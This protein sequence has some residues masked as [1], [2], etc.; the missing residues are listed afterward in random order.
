MSYTQIDNILGQPIPDYVIN[1]LKIRSKKTLDKRDNQALVYTANKSGWVRV[2]SS[3]DVSGSLS[4]IPTYPGPELA[5]N[6]VLFGGMS[7]Y[8]N[9]GGSGFTYE[10]KPYYSKEAFDQTY[11]FRPMAGITNAKI[12]TQGKLGSILIAEIDFKANT[13]AQLDLIDILYFKIG[14][15]MLVEWG[16]TFY[17]K[18][19]REDA[20]NDLLVEDTLRK[21][22]DSAVDPF[23]GD[24]D[25]ETIRIKIAKAVRET[26]GNYGGMLGIVTNYSFSINSEGGYDCRIKIMAPGMLA[27]SMRVNSL[28]SLPKIYKEAINLLASKLTAI[29]QKNAEIE[30][31]NRRQ[32]E[33]QELSKDPN[34]YPPCVRNLIGNTLELKTFSNGVTGATGKNGEGPFKDYIFYYNYKYSVNQK[35]S[36]KYSCDPSTNRVLNENGEPFSGQQRTTKEFVSDILNGKLPASRYDLRKV[37]QSIEGKSEIGYRVED[38]QDRLTYFY[39]TSKDKLILIQ[40]SGEDYGINTAKLNIDANSLHLYQKNELNTN[41]LTVL[42]EKTSGKVYGDFR[43]AEYNPSYDAKFGFGENLTTLYEAV[44]SYSVDGK[45]VDYSFEVRYD[46][47]YGEVRSLKNTIDLVSEKDNRAAIEEAIYNY[48]S[49][50]NNTYSLKFLRLGAKRGDITQIVNVEAAAVV[51]ATIWIN[52]QIQDVAAK[53]TVVPQKQTVKVP[54]AI[55]F[56]DFNL[57]SQLIPAP[58]S[59]NG[60]VN[61]ID[62]NQSSQLNATQTPPETQQDYVSIDAKELQNFEQAM[63]TSQLETMLRVV[64][65]TTISETISDIGL[66]DQVKSI[67]WTDDKHSDRLYNGLFIDGAMR[68]IAGSILRDVVNAT[69]D[70][71]KEGRISDESR[72]TYL[73]GSMD[74][75][76]RYK[77]NLYYGFHRG[78]MKIDDKKKTIFAE[79]DHPEY[80]VNFKEL[81]TSY[82]IPYYQSKNLVDGGD[83][84]YPTY[85]PLGFF[86]M[87]LNHCCFLY[88]TSDA[89]INIPMFYLDFNQGSNVM[90]SSEFMLTANPYKFVVPFTGNSDSYKKLFDKD[91]ISKDGLRIGSGSDSS[92]LWKYDAVSD[93]VPKFKSVEKSTNN[94]VVYRGKTMNALVSIDYL[95]D[96]VKRHSQRDETN[97]VYFRPLIEEIF[98]DLG[99]CLGSFNIFRLA[100]DDQSNCFYVT[101]DQFIPGENVHYEDSNKNIELPLFGKESIARSLSITTEN[102][103]KLGSTAFVGAN[104]DV[105]NQ[106]TLGIDGTSIGGLNLFAIDRYKK[107]TTGAND[108]A[109]IAISNSSSDRQQRAVAASRFNEAVNSFYYGGLRSEGMVDQ[110]VNYYIERVAKARNSDADPNLRAAMLLPI[111]VNFNTDGISSMAIYQAFTINEELLPYSYKYGMGQTETRK[112]GFIITGLEHTIQNNTWTT[113][114]K[115]NMYYVKRKGDYKQKVGKQD[116]AEKWK[117]IPLVLLTSGVNATNNGIINY[118]TNFV[119][120]KDQKAMDAKKTAEQ[121]LGRT[122]IDNDWNCL[123]AAAYAESNY[124]DRS[125]QATWC[126]AVMINRARNS[127]RT[128]YEELTLPLQFQAVTGTPRNG[129]LPSDNYVKGPSSSIEFSIYDGIIAELIK[130]DKRYVNFTSNLNSAYVDGTDISYKRKLEN[131]PGKIIVGDTIFSFA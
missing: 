33:A 48:V 24:P 49:D 52:K 116:K 97:S 108:N 99:K 41:L 64:Q 18:Q 34:S 46:N 55:I 74:K 12:I 123:I 63:Y 26:E 130:I 4:G 13:K 35:G 51:E 126:A 86:F 32:Q 84:H 118:R 114:V 2:V 42:K 19:K 103:S 91:L 106:S 58:N 128:I 129:S 95:L 36:I 104:S 22:E 20:N 115:A 45:K 88:D 69:G 43:L 27:E 37:Y 31:Q 102:S 16:N 40:N 85:I 113:D 90:L 98:S 23:T 121:Y 8:K 109:K 61:R 82:V 100:Y 29:N 73:N 6:N 94:T 83:I 56:N 93:Y 14:Y 39:S 7:A 110:A 122:L 79:L 75:M 28:N 60:F 78:L 1:Q 11:G 81:L 96:I 5:K 15:S 65:I 112:V 21:S 59:I 72:T 76:L 57:F 9:T 111:S 89:N 71:F 62:V 50:K 66:L 30:K 119:A 125:K 44:Y 25:K 87:M 3:V 17:Y 80:K 117:D 124:K 67:T 107:V 127:R 10:L 54:F 120:S 47:T 92:D 68:S 77:T 70:P 53:E 131:S 101:D 105:R 38:K